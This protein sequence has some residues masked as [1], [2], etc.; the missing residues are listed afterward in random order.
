MYVYP[1]TSQHVPDLSDP[2]CRWHDHCWKQ[3]RKDPRI[4]VDPSWQICDDRTRTSPTYLGMQIEQNLRR[5]HWEV[6]KNIPRYLWGTEDAQLTFKTANPT[7]IEGYT[8]SDYADNLD[9]RKSTL[10]YIFTYGGGTISWRLKLQEHTTLSTTKA[11]YILTSE[12]TKDAI[13]FK[14]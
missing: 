5:T 1:A 7:G 14:V 3:S 6:I 9:N 12:A 13:W 8:D 4:K 10:G 11:K 2:L